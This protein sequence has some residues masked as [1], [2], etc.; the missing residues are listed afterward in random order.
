M[1]TSSYTQGHVSLTVLEQVAE[2]VGEKEEE[3]EEEEEE[4]KEEEEVSDTPLNV[5]LGNHHCCYKD[6]CY[7]CCCY[8]CRSSTTTTTTQ[9]VSECAGQRVVPGGHG[10]LW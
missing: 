7:C 8:H 5:Y 2:G 6:H 9:A 10:L 1:N 4:E 3:E